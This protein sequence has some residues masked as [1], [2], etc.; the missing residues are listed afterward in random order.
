[1]KEISA[2]ISKGKAI[3]EVEEPVMTTCYDFS[4]PPPPP[5][6]PNFPGGEKALIEFLSNYR[7][8]VVAQ[9]N[10][11]EGTTICS[12]IINKTG[13]VSDVKVIKSVDK[14]LDKEAV[15]VI[16]MMPPW[17]PAKINGE[18]ESVEKTVAFVAKLIGGKETDTITPTRYTEADYEIVVKGYAPTSISSC[19]TGSIHTIVSNTYTAEFAD[20]EDYI[21]K[22]LVYPPEMIKDSIEGSVICQ[23]K[24]SK[25]GR[26]SRIKVIQSLHPALDKEAV[27]LIKSMP[28]WTPAH[29]NGKP[30]ESKTT[31]EIDFEL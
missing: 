16:Q 21:E 13:K 18:E 20:V 9:E 7:Y 24:V 29:K 23:F 6:P 3:G 31:L 17:K 10:S 25:R 5:N 26:I 19:Y 27:R 1:M 2:F 12:F 4:Y 28:K 14:S 30:V 22:H 8:P 15:R 11:V